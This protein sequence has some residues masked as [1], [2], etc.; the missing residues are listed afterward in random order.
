MMEKSRLFLNKFKIIK[1]W[2]IDIDLSDYRWAL[3]YLKD[4]KIPDFIF[5]KPSVLMGE[6]IEFLINQVCTKNRKWV[7]CFSDSVTYI[8]TLY[9][10]VVATF[11]LS[12]NLNA[13]IKSP[14]GLIEFA[15]GKQS[16][17]P[18]DDELPIQACALLMF[19]CFEATHPGYIKA[20]PKIIEL[21]TDRKIQKKPFIFSLYSE[22][23]PKNKED[24]PKF[25]V[26]LT[27]FFG[28]QA[29]DLFSDELTKFVI[30][31]SE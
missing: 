19:Q 27:D 3:Y 15:F 4:R 6:R 30:L 31:K 13:E 23:L 16:F 21:L 7:I 1:P 28:K 24:I 20:R 26:S 29:R 2:E 17:L 11:V 8:R 25:S 10:Y 22:N 18:A 9:A 12:T 14:Q 5:S